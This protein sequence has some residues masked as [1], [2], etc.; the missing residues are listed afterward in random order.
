VD[1]RAG[2]FAAQRLDGRPHDGGVPGL[3]RHLL[4]VQ[5]QDPAAF[6]LALRARA[7]GIT[8]SDLT[9]ARAAR[10]V[11]RCWGPRGTLHLIAAEDLAWLYPLVS[12]APAG[13][14]R[15]LRQLGVEAGPDKVVAAV[16]AALSGQGPLTKERL[17]QRLAEQGLPVTGQGIV[18]AAMLAAG[19]GLV[20]L[21]PEYGGKPS[22][23][24]AADWL[25]APLPTEAAGREA[26]VGMLVARYQAAHHPCEPADLAAWSGLPL[27]EVRRAWAAT[28]GYRSAPLPVRLIPAF[29]EYLL[30]WRDRDHA[31]PAAFRRQA[32]P[33]GGIIRSAVLVDGLVTGT[34]RMRRTAG[35]VDITVEPFAPLPGEALPGEV[36]PG[37][38]AEAAAIGSFLG[39]PA[40]ISAAS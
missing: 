39:L 19:R 15:R 32:H 11:V 7:A 40:R 17:G 4:A 21:G 16:D 38:A 35:R 33:G 20:V 31:V 27:G 9:E 2:R 10:T 13:S 6:P 37:L 14:V 8:A 28:R 29:D 36:L 25:G 26:A 34:W 23:V 12:P 18:H 22:Y 30:G 1:E 24:H 3:V 5:A